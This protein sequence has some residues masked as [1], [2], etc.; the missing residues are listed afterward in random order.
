MGHTQNERKRFVA[1]TAGVAGCTRPSS[2]T[3]AGFDVPEKIRMTTLTLTTVLR[4]VVALVDH[5]AYAKRDVAHRTALHHRRTVRKSLSDR[6]A[7][8]ANM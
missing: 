2:G 7:R 6:R 5:L 8:A 1:L 4:L 3:N